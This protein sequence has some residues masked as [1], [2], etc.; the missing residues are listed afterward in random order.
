MIIFWNWYFSLTAFYVIL[1]FKI[2]PPE[3]EFKEFVPRLKPG[4]KNG[5]FHLK[6]YS[7]FQD[8]SR[9]SI[10]TGFSGIWGAA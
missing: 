3:A 10:E 1:T 4:L 8:L 9:R 5:W 7:M 6:S 2:E